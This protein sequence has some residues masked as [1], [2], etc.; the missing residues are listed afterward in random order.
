MQPARA[1]S[2]HPK[3][4][5]DEDDH[6]DE[7]DWADAKQIPRLAAEPAAQEVR[8]DALLTV[9][10]KSIELANLPIHYRSFGSYNAISA[11]SF[12]SLHPRDPPL[13]GKLNNPTL[14]PH[15]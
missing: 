5:Q 3:N 13:S 10:K 7:D 14:N 6:D 2:Y 4:G 15:V 8:R 1:R 11:S 9:I 12:R